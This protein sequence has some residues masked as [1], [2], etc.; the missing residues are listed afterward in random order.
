M[1]SEHVLF[2]AAF[3]Q[4][5]FSVAAVLVG[6][7]EGLGRENFLRGFRVNPRL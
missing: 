2:F 7:R 3:E 1:R 5:H 6:L 4:H